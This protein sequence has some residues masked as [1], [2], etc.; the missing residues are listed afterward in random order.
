[1]KAIRN[2]YLAAKAEIINYINNINNIKYCFI[3]PLIN[4]SLGK[5][6]PKDLEPIVEYSFYMVLALLITLSCFIHLFGY[7]LTIYIIDK[8]NF[9]TKFSK[10]PLIIRMIKYYRARTTIFMVYEGLV[11]IIFLLLMLISNLYLGGV[12][13]FNI[14]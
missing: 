1:M 9:E 12:I 2:I 8:Y 3:M 11:C 7:I 5:E 14:R 10:Y 4:Y 6:L 13:L